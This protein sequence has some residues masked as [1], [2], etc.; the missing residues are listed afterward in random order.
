LRWRDRKDRLVWLGFVHPTEVVCAET[1]GDVVPALSRIDAAV[2]SGAWAAGFLAYEAAQGVDACLT[3]KQTCPVPMVWFGVF[4]EPAVVEAELPPPCAG[5]EPSA[6]AQSWAPSVGRDAFVGAIGAIRRY[7]RAGDT[8]QV[9][10]SFRMRNRLSASPASVFA[11]MLSVQTTPYA[12][13]VDTGRHVLASV[14]P[15]LFF[16]VDGDTVTCR[17]MKGT[18]R[19]G[20]GSGEDDAA[21]SELAASE[22]NRAENVMIVDMIRNDLGR[23]AVPGSVVVERLFDVERYETVLQMT[24]T[25]SARSDAG[26]ASLMQ[27]MFPC[28][29]VTGAPKRRTMEIIAELESDPRGIYTGAIGF[30]GPGRVG[31][32]SVAIRT[33][34]VDRETGSAEYGTGAG[35][36]WDSEA[37]D[38]Y[39]ECMDKARVLWRSVAPFRLLETMLWTPAR[40]FRLLAAHMRRMERSAGY[41]G[42]RFD[43]EAAIARL[44]NAAA[45]LGPAAHRVRLLLTRSG[46]VAVETA[47]LTPRAD[48]ELVVALAAKPVKASD[49][50]VRHKTTSRAVYDEARSSAPGADDVLLWNESGEVTESCI[51]NVVLRRGGRWV[52]P[53]EGCGLL[54]GTL[55][56]RLIA[57]GWVREEPVHA[58]S[59]R[60]GERVYLVNSVRGI[61]PARFKAGKG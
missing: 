22:K 2:A 59:M 27:A 5:V 55:R 24:S 23:V 33:L 13:L 50:F 43:R 16:R 40:G 6:P 37:E 30:W 36:V 35:I 9:N 3:T 4:R 31:Q 44:E 54:P 25:V 42:F 14:S 34:Q 45:G 29:S 58:A 47:P 49:P 61:V 41:F 11:A 53:P 56:E 21:A 17:P 19:R 7:L 39:T 10:F 15:E 57:R 51:A 38:E 46:E 1:A 52:T 32:F 18:A 20:A 28:A 60:D 8:Y 48:R 12:S 26:L